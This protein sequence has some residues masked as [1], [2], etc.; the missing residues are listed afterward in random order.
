MRDSRMVGVPPC[1][2]C[3]SKWVIVR[4]DGKA[5]CRKCGKLWEPTG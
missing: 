4:R 2:H 5:A 1:P 3:G